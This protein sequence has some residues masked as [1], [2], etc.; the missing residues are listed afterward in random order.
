MSFWVDKFE[1][2][3]DERGFRKGKKTWLFR[4]K[5]TLKFRGSKFFGVISRG[6]TGKYVWVSV[7]DKKKWMQFENR[8]G[9]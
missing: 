1:R 8:K 6:S 5:I 2:R 9:V 3:M 4:G 7:Y